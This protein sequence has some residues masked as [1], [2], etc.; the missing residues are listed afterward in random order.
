MIGRLR[1]HLSGWIE[2]AL[3]ARRSDREMAKLAELQDLLG[4]RFSDVELLRMALT[5]RSCAFA[6]G[7]S[8]VDSNERMEFLGDAVL[9][10]VVRQNLLEAHPDRT[11]GE[12]TEIKARLV[13]GSVLAEV[14]R[15]LGLG[16]YLGLS[17]A[18]KAAGGEDRDS[19]LGDAFEALIGAI[20]LDGGL[21]A[22]RVFLEDLGVTDTS[23]LVGQPSPKNHKSALLEY[24]QG[25]GKGH[26]IY[27]LKT[28]EGP[29]H[30][31]FFT[32]EVR[33]SG[34]PVGVGQGRTKKEAEQGAA[35]QALERIASPR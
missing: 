33:V 5:H 32:V 31:K 1:Y 11:E 28:S 3:W 7:G 6:N 4:Y 14:A 13:A 25:I 29:D 16:P 34:K 12:M 18:E 19:I 26:P 9:E 15:D 24:A 8:V 30:A 2:R 23:D 17:D 20:H 27:V 10:L 22:A 21:E 35:R